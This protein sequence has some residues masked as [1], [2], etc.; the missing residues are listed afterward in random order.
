MAHLNST[1]QPL[2][3]NIE[4]FMGPALIGVFSSATFYLLTCYLTYQYFNR[5]QDDVWY[6]KFSTNDWDKDNRYRSSH[7]RNKHDL[8][9]SYP[10]LRSTR[11]D[12]DDPENVTGYVNA[13][14]RIRGCLSYVGLS[15]S[16]LPLLMLIGHYR[17]VILKV[18]KLSAYKKETAVS[19]FALILI[20]T[21]FSIGMAV[22][23]FKIPSFLR[24]HEYEVD[25]D[26]TSHHNVQLSNTTSF[27]W[28]FIG[29]LVLDI[30]L[31]MTLCAVLSYFLLAN[32]TR[33]PNSRTDPIVFR[34]IQYLVGTGVLSC[35]CGILTLISVLAFPKTL[36][37]LTPLILLEKCTETRLFK[38]A[39]TP[40]L[41]EGKDESPRTGTI[42]TR[43]SL[44]HQVPHQ[45]AIRPSRI[46]TINEDAS[47]MAAN[48][49]NEQVAY[50]LASRSKHGLHFARIL[51]LTRY[52][53]DAAGSI[54]AAL[55][56]RGPND[57]DAGD[58]HLPMY[59][60]RP[61]MT[62]YRLSSSLTIQGG[63]VKL[64]APK[65]VPEVKF[66]NVGW[67]CICNGY[68]G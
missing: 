35:A 55:R 39:S 62:R 3:P 1:N 8:S 11:N 22:E 48:S 38:P 20:R 44:H 9:I 18:W 32:R 29:T 30:V 6:Y 60:F 68:G 47:R 36:I 57:G 23:A 15:R 28:T 12:V 19:L 58:G 16:E 56:G 5:F 24:V 14:Y 4:V 7:L 51:G 40:S 66:E 45:L 31:D 50:M 53:L 49:Q 37:Y 17:N 52:E 26:Y 41:W 25:A 65:V 67:Q 59:R 2:G 21:A 27:Q 10:S 54:N 46:H 63:G 43:T 13:Q 64:T 33:N 34:I 61:Q 42:P